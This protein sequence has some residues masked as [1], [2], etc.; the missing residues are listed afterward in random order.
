MKKVA[1]VIL[2]FKVAEEVVKCIKSVQAS[3]YANLQIIVVDNNSQDSL[4]EKLR[5]FKSIYFYANSENSGY[6]GGN[7]IGIKLAIQLGVEYIL[8]LNPDTTVDKNCIENLVKGAEKLRV[9]VVGPKIYFSGTE[10]IWYAGG[11][12]NLA[13]VIGS[14]R[15]VDEKDTGQY[16]KAEETDYVTGAAMLI[17]VDVIKKIGM[18]DE[19]FFL[20]YEDA[21]FCMRA[22]KAGFKIFYIPDAQVYHDNA[23]SAG[24]GSPLQDYFITRN[25]MLYVSKFLSFR[26]RF[27]LFREALRNINSPV[28][29]L[30]F[31]DFLIGNFG[32]GSFKI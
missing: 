22:K 24:L 16:D 8:I 25:R 3:T 29:R 31:F 18:F 5:N 13:N 17:N 19:N 2:N 15:G 1:V 23:K 7:N 14:H 32:K 26:T 11:I 6:T 30:A 20:Y 10:K 27:A 4:E 28:R 12:M 21:D 9:G